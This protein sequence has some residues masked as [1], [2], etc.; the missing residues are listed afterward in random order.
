MSDKPSSLKRRVLAA[1]AA[2]PAC[3]FVATIVANP[4]PAQ[5]ATPGADEHKNPLTP[6]TAIPTDGTTTQPHQWW[7]NGWRHPWGNWNNWHNWPNWNNWHNWS[8]F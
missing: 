1:I 8:N 2:G 7:H 4:T 5:A 3:I 6:A